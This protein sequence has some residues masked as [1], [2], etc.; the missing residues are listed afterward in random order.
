MQSTTKRLLL[1]GLL[2]LLTLNSHV[3]AQA[4]GALGAPISQ[5]NGNGLE[6]RLRQAT[7][8]N[9]RISYHARTSTVSFIGADQDHP[10]GRPAGL[11][12]NASPEALARAFLDTYG[13]LFGVKD[14]SQE[15]RLKRVKDNERGHSM[16]RLQQTHHGI[17]VIAGEL[18][19]NLDA[20]GSIL[21]ANGELLPDLQLDVNPT[22]VAATA[23]QRAL[24]L[25][26]KSYK[27]RSEV[28]TVTEPELWIYDSDLL[29]APGLQR[30]TLVWRMDVESAANDVRELVLV[31][32]KLGTVALHF[33]QIADARDRRVCDNSSAIGVSDACTADRYVRIEGQGATGNASV[34]QVYDYTGNT[35][36]FYKNRFGRDSLDAKGM[37]LLSTVRYCPDYFNCPFQNAYWNGK[38]MVYGE[39]VDTDDVVGHELTHGV[40]QYESGLFYYYQSGAIN[41]SLSDVFGELIDLTNGRGNDSANVRWDVAEDS[42]LGTIRNMMEPT[43]YYNPD[44]MTSYFYATD[45]GDNGGVHSNSGV[46][47]KAAALMVDGGSFNGKTI[48]GLG[49]DKTA[50]I[51]YEVETNLLTSGSDYQDLYNALQQACANLAGSGGI[52][53][54]DCQQVKNAVD[55][56][57]M[58]IAAPAG[59][60]ATD[61]PVCDAGLS[62]NNLFF[63]NLENPSSGN[64]VLQTLRGTNH[65]YY[66][67]NSHP[68][69]P[70][71]DETYA[72]SG[73]YNIWGDDAGD[74]LSDPNATDKT[75]D[76]ALARSASLALPVGAYLRFNH[77]YGFEDD[78]FS[79]YDGGVF[80]YSVDNG[81]TWVDAGN[82]FTHNGYDGSLDSTN[83]LG[84]RQAFVGQSHGYISSRLD[85]SSLAGKSFRF[86]FRMGIDPY[87]GDYGWYI[88]D[89]RIYTC[90]T[91]TP[92]VTLNPTSLSFGSQQIGMTSAPQ[93]VTLTNSGT[94]ALSISGIA[95][96]G[97][98]SGDFAKTTTCGS[99]LAAAAS[100]AINVTFT[101]TATG[102]RSAT[103]QVTDNAAGSPHGV[104]LSGTGATAPPAS[105]LL[106][107][108]GFELDANGDTKPDSWSQN[109]KF[110]RSNVGPHGG[111]YDG[112]LRATD[113][114]GLTISQTITS[115]TAGTTYKFA[116]WVNIPAQND[117]TFTFKLQVSWR[118]ASNTTIST[119]TIKSYTA[120]TGGWNQAT[121]SLVAPAGTT[122]AR[123]QL[124]ASSLN[125]AIYVDDVS[126]GP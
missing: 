121:A 114:S 31:D 94:T 67:Q 102:S 90:G 9:V 71:Y 20:A 26:M 86:R 3:V 116:G 43:F 120:A 82:L 96:A 19:V 50:K 66:P 124:V 106:A 84:A 126:L 39:G 56:T 69:G 103:L 61:A 83:P 58:N 91:Q 8:G 27:L 35:Y 34:D 81:T 57:E 92:A 36:D 13:P 93:T 125:G 97:T 74:D 11:S 33:N 95:L 29:G 123:V 119:K 54:T 122:N 68:Y 89:I 52:T 30:P 78:Y 60:E 40:T 72:T 112:K 17:P 98:N 118:N 76:F 46:N 21:S 48:T 117:A 111:S 101:P 110:T 65:F 108:S 63:D 107:N 79:N 47:N 109:N 6:D 99:S 2:S 113:N 25:A 85:L 104:P 4:R 16:V 70:D 18:N 75:A 37:A 7:G 15:L 5:G 45:D 42:S 32:A 38:Q 115:L 59:A 105:N 80:E 77:A 10:I 12:S 64:W 88:D 28:L 100:C 23:K 53:S 41:E 49:I 73:V 62:P 87:V 1:I 22:V 14:Q 51:Y 44:K 24:G 55:A